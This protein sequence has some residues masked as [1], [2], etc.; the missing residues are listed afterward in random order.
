MSF[1]A[2]IRG[3]LGCAVAA[4]WETPVWLWQIIGSYAVCHPLPVTYSLTWRLWGGP[5]AK[6]PRSA[7]DGGKHSTGWI[8]LVGEVFQRY[9]RDLLAKSDRF[10][11]G[12]PPR[13]RANL[14][15]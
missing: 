1:F 5:L 10:S 15:R 2:L 12:V 6:R 8:V 14:S 9:G 13:L 11:A 3:G 4:A 7:G